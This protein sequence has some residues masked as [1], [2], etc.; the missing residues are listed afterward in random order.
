MNG[1]FFI[2]KLTISSSKI[3]CELKTMFM[4]LL[5]DILIAFSDIFM[6]ICFNKCLMVIYACRNTKS[7]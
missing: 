5:D 7:S 3:K 1:L 4:G 2:N 6:F